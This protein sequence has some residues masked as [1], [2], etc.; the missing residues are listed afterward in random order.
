MKHK[1]IVKYDLGVYMYIYIYNDTYS[2]YIYTLE[3]YPP[4]N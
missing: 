3:D 1:N 2:I 4:G